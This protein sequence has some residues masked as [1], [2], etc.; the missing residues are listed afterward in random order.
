MIDR[1]LRPGTDDFIPHRPAADS[2]HLP[3]D[4]TLYIDVSLFVDERRVKCRQKAQTV[5]RLFI[6]GRVADARL[7]QPPATEAE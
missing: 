1:G 6:V 2:T 3:N 7:L 4:P 5:L